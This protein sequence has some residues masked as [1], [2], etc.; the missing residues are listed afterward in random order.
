[1]ER[2]SIKFMLV[3]FMSCCITKR[4]GWICWYW[5]YG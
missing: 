5:S 2:H 1:V 3:R 4:M